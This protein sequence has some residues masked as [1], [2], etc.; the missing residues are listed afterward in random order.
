MYMCESSLSCGVCKPDLDPKFPSIGV[1]MFD[2]DQSILII[3]I[4]STES[5]KGSITL[6]GGSSSTAPAI[7]RELTGAIS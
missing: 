5:V 2:P 4:M 7:E 1:Y 6:I 3:G